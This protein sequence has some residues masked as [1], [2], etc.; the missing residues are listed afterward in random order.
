M[1]AVWD[2]WQGSVAIRSGRTGERG[3]ERES[4]KVRRDDVG[5][6]EV[7]AHGSLGP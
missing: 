2:F 6:A 5:V 1:P 3:R 7:I 4:A